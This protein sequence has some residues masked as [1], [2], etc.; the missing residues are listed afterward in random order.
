MYGIAKTH[1]DISHPHAIRILNNFH[2]FTKKTLQKLEE[3]QWIILSGS[4]W[5][6]TEEGFQKAKNLYSQSSSND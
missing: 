4:Q 2:G 6:L 1:E 3:K 5:S